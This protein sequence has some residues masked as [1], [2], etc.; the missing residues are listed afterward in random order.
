VNLFTISNKEMERQA[1]RRKYHYLYVTVCR[2]T[3]RYYIGMHSTDD[4]EDGYLG[5]GKRLW[6][7]INKHGRD[8]HVMKV[9]EFLPNR[10]S[11]ALLEKKIVNKEVLKDPQ[12]MNLAL[13]GGGGGWDHVNSNS[14]L[15]KAKNKKSIEVLKELRNNPE[16]KLIASKNKSKGIKQS[17]IDGRI[18]KLP[19]WNGKSHKSE[20]KAKIGAINSLLQT[21]SGNSQFGK[22]W[23]HSIELK[24]SLSV[25][26]SVLD[27]YLDAGWKLG[28]KMKFE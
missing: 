13:G 17:Y 18:P 8:Q 12:C 15:Q 1:T 22:K 25:S 10:E 6:H 9:L 27:S 3:L 26:S 11:L 2:V 14:E 5:S 21:G 19:N 23:I 28:R 4:L 16:W 24:S 7:S 20:S